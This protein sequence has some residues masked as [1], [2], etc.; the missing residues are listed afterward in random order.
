M[1]SS[2]GRAEVHPRGF[3]AELRRPAAATQP[4]A[5]TTLP[6]PGVPTRPPGPA[7]APPWCGPGPPPCAR[8]GCA[9]ATRRSRRFLPGSRRVTLPP[10]PPLRPPRA[11]LSRPRAESPPPRGDPAT[12]PSSNAQPTLPHAQVLPKPDAKQKNQEKTYPNCNT[13]LI[14]SFLDL[15]FNF[16]NNKSRNQKPPRLEVGVRGNARGRCFILSAAYAPPPFSGPCLG[17]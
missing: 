2:F 3:V 14:Q 1:L 8:P 16:K 17:L 7:Q 10:V 6:Q 13:S 5:T 4:R 11:G 15:T 12:K 9:T